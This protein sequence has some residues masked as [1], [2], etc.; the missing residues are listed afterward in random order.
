MTKEPLRGASW[1]RTA[2]AALLLMM[3]VAAQGAIDRKTIVRRNNPH[4][5]SVGERQFLLGNGQNSINVDATALQTFVTK[6]A[7]PFIVGLNLSDTLR[8]T[9]LQMTLDRWNGKADSRFSYDG[10]RYHVET[11]HTLATFSTKRELMSDRSK[12]EANMVA[13]RINCDTTFEVRLTPLFP[14]HSPASSLKVIHLKNHAAIRAADGEGQTCWL[15][16][17]WTGKVAIRKQAGCV[18]LRSKEKTLE[19]QFSVARANPNDNFY[20]TSWVEPFSGEAMNVA[21]AWSSYWM[22]YGFADFSA[23]DDPAARRLEQRMVAALYNMAASQ[24]ED[25]WAMAPFTLYGFPQ[26]A[27]IAVERHARKSPKELAAR[28]EF[29]ALAEMTLRAYVGPE[30]VSR[31]SVAR[32]NLWRNYATLIGAYGPYVAQAAS[33]LAAGPAPTPTGSLRWINTDQLPAVA[34]R[35]QEAYDSLACTD[36]LPTE[37]E[38]LYG[39]TEN[40]LFSVPDD[41]AID[42]LSDSDFLLML[43]ARRWPQ[44]WPVVVENILPLP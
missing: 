16:L 12:T 36:Q 8:L 15:L 21:T 3:A 20:N 13:T 24:P 33:Q 26:Q 5:E 11:V 42:S 19:L 25:W 31:H 7:G 4:A 9:D 43:A 38:T 28:P 2:C 10:H 29:I 27:S 39:F 22:E 40:Q 6:G 37:A 41:V 30:T 44:A 34:Q 32:E 23:V 35:W 1:A 17:S 18:V 14:D